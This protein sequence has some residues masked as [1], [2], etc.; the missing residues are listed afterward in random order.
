MLKVMFAV[1]RFAVAL[2]CISNAAHAQ[3]KTCV[4]NCAPPSGG[5]GGGGGNTYYAP[6]APQMSANRREALRLNQLGVEASFRYDFGT[7]LYYFEQA[8]R[9]DPHDAVI[10]RSVRHMRGGLA[11]QRGRE[12]RD[13][14]DLHAALPLLKQACMLWPEDKSGSTCHEYHALEGHLI[15]QRGQTEFNAGRYNNAIA[16]YTQALKHLPNNSLLQDKIKLARE[17]A[18]RTKAQPPQQIGCLSDEAS[19]NQY[20]HDL[21]ACDGLTL[22]S[23]PY[24]ECINRALEKYKACK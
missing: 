7:A 24:Y 23:S 17:A 19:H 21:K 13:R 1:T 12:A 4:Y 11:S 6:P 10:R 20:A 16:F 2:L 5:G 9:Y 15:E 14:G 3:G 8:A 22:N 18:N